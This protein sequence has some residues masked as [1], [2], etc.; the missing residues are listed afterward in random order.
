MSI[1]EEIS[2]IEAS[3]MLLPAFFGELGIIEVKCFLTKIGMLFA[4][5]LSLLFV[6][7]IVAKVTSVF[8]E[9][10]ERGGSI[11]KKVDFSKHIIICGWNFQ[12]KRIVKELQNEDLKTKKNIVILANLDTR[13]VQDEKI[14][15]IKGEPTQDEDLINAGVK[16]A[17]S[18]IVLSDLRKEA[19]E[20]DAEAL[21]IVLAVESLNREVHT[22]VQ[23][24]NSANRIHLERAHSDEII[25]LD[26]LGGSLSV[27]SSL[28]P[29]VSNIV[30]EL[31]TFNSGSEFYRYEGKLSDEIIGKEFSEVICI[32]AK[33]K[34]ILLAVEIDDSQEVRENL[35]I[36]VLHRGDEKGRLIIVNP[37]SPYTI[38]QGDALFIVAE[39][40]PIKL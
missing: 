19:N 3:V 24:L 2:F 28:N 4:L 38:R 29:G 5:L 10:I 35:S 23:I 34:M 36:D 13:P 31:L 33:R 11:V 30:T 9:F 40:E 16:T 26:Q 12:G 21:M 18:V 37:Q 15:F 14:E 7:V 20:A 32:L 27:A 8:V 25:C 1:L 22:S 39:S 17:S 6:A